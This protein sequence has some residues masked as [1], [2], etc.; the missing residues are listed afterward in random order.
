MALGESR[1]RV[2]RTGIDLGLQ[3]RVERVVRGFRGPGTD[4]LA[5]VVLDR[6]SGE[7]RAMVGSRDYRTHPLNACL[8]ERPAGST[9]KPFLYALAFQDGI[10]GPDGLLMDTPMR[11]GDYVPANFT[12][13]FAGRIRAGEALALSRNVPAIRLLKKVGVD[14]FRD[15]LRELGLGLRERAL[16][17]DLALGTESVSPLGLAR[18]WRRFAD[19]GA[20]L[21][22]SWETRRK[23]LRVLSA[24][25]PDPGILPPGRAAWKTGTSSNRR[26]A[27]TVGVAGDFVICVWLGNL[28][29][30]C[31]PGLVGMDSAALL[32]AQI[33]CRI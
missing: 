13:D 19:P 26:D 22:L 3:R 33:Q 24:W 17:L 10:V 12:R 15:L 4:G 6:R 30:R 18:A 7:I 28:D 16:Y 25:S 32:F 27:W 21:S 31:D 9:L 23:V 5:L 20:D 1:E 2:V 11:I 8:C 29:D 14:R